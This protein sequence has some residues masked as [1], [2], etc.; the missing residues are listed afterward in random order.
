[1]NR[2]RTDVQKQVHR[3]SNVERWA[4]YISIDITVNI[5]CCGKHRLMM[6]MFIFLIGLDHLSIDAVQLLYS[7]QNY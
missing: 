5:V 4:V 7:L 6:M 2:A 3:K 1:M